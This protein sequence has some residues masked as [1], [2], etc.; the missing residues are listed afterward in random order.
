[1]S[2][3]EV[4]GGVEKQCEDVEQQSNLVKVET[5]LTPDEIEA[6]SRIKCSIC[7]EH[8]SFEDLQAHSEICVAP[9]PAHCM[10]VTDKWA[11]T[12]EALSKTQLDK[13]LQMRREEEKKRVAAIERE[14]TGQRQG[15]WIPGRFFYVI[16]SSWL[17]E[18]RQ[19][20]DGNLERPPGPIYNGGLFSVDGKELVSTLKE[21]IDSGDY[22]FLQPELWTFFIQNYGG[23]PS[24]L[25]YV[26]KWDRE[27][28][29]NRKILNISKSIEFY[30]DFKSSVPFSGKGCI[31]D[32]END[33]GFEGELLEGY[34][35]NGFGKGLLPDGSF[36]E[37]KVVQGL[38]EG[39]GRLV[40]ASGEEYFGC[41]VRGKLEGSATL[42]T[43]H[44]DKIEGNFEDG[45]LCGI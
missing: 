5:V 6:C 19:F 36:F 11:H 25:R 35:H 41:F 43:V 40:M 32:H 30:G 3:T 28:A 14:K 39:E 17:R 13:F 21:G 23:G 16:S 29:R 44:G 26:S 34:L 42:I 33:V 24:I 27:L 22:Y 10:L 9:P 7:N 4:E 31:W 45:Q 20:I 8:V 38:P 15:W 1:M 37:G 12:S 18:W 2:G